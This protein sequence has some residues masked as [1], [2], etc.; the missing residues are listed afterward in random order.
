MQIV[1]KNIIKNS[2]KTTSQYKKQQQRFGSEKHNTFTEE[3][4]KI[5]L[6]ANVDKRMQSIDS[7]E[8]YA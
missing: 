7:I 1:L 2:L 3:I 5:A 4:N 6:S 8:T